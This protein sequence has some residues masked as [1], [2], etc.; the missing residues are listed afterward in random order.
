MGF[1]FNGKI[2]CHSI[3]ACFTDTV[4]RTEHIFAST[5]RRNVHDE[6]LLMPDHDGGCEDTGCVIASKANP[7]LV[8]PNRN[9]ML[10]KA[11]VHSRRIGDLINVVDQNIQT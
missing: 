3:N 2:L 4:A 10:P 6:S 9:R 11:L 1:E 7:A 8:I 5:S